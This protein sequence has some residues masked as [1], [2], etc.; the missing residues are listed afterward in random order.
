MNWILLCTLLISFAASAAEP[1][2]FIFA[3]PLD[4]GALKPRGA[5]TRK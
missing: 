1:K 2:Q 3:W 5:T 4:E